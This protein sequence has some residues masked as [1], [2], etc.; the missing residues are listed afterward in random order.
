[1][2]DD[3]SPT[4]R[5]ALITGAGRRIGRAVALAL[6]R[7]GYAVVLHANRSRAAAEKLAAEIVATSGRA[8]VV[9][10]DLAMPRR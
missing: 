6:S 7:A 1:M 2:P 3:K 9:L 10:G 4:P 5:A 8:H